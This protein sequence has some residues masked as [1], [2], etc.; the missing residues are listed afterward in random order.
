MLTRLFTRKPTP[1]SVDVLF[2]DFD[3]V[4]HPISGIGRM[5]SQ[6][7]LL[8][9]LFEDNPDLRIVVSSD[10]RFGY[11]DTELRHK[12][13]ALQSHFAGSTPTIVDLDKTHFPGDPRIAFSRQREILWYL[14]ENPAVRQWTAVDD[15]P[16]L[17]EPDF[18]QE[19][20]ILT[21]P[22]TGITDTDVEKIR[23]H[24]R[25]TR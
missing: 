1:E 14:H 20:V 17:F 3:G 6:N 2:L 19:H 23:H 16:D 15:I 12:L 5:F 10:W 8:L 13:G 21:D 22:H 18:C 24:L 25:R 4:L 9:P 7:D 11:S